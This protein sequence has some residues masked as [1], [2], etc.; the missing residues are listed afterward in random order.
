MEYRKHAESLIETPLE[1][2]REVLVKHAE[3]VIGGTSEE[4]TR[5]TKQR[6]ELVAALERC[7]EMVGHPDNISFIDEALAKVKGAK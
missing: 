2:I 3:G 6:D 7:R 5:L 4:I 1:L